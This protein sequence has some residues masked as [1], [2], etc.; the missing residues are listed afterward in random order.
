M[1][2]PRPMTLFQ[3]LHWIS[4]RLLVRTGYRWEER[5]LGSASIGLL[6]LSLQKRKAGPPLGSKRRLVVLP[7]F[8]DS[9]LTWLPLLAP[10]QR[11]LAE[12]FDEV[13]WVDFPGYRGFLAHIRPFESMD[14]M[15]SATFDVLDSL[16]PLVLLGHSL[17]GW[18]AAAYAVECGEGKRCAPGAAKPLRGPE[19]L[20]LF[21]PSGVMRREED[22]ERWRGIFERAARV[23]SEIYMDFLFASP[24]AHTRAIARLCAPEMRAF[25]NQPEIAKF[26]ASVSAE[27]FVTHSLNHIQADT[28]VAWGESDQVNFSDW[29]QDWL[30]LL[31]QNA[32]SGHGVVFK[33]TGHCPH[34]ENPISTA[35]LLKTVL[36]NPE[37]SAQ[38]P[39]KWAN[40]SV[41]T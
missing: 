31:D 28:W 36:L 1:L 35:Q 14:S 34:I 38:L 7:G 30:H 19:Q 6:R 27:H 37:A 40:W 41:L 5:R 20:I 16:E 18:L 24:R 39:A 21:N 4:R 22:A 12:K 2:E 17:G 26:I 10:M 13:V 25:F 8:G 9:P 15:R 29:L 23:E 11:A 32:K 33:G 3:G